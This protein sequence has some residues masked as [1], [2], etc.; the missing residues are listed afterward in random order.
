MV[1]IPDSLKPLIHSE[2]Y[3]IISV[4]SFRERCIKNSRESGFEG[5]LFEKRDFMIV[6]DH[7][8]L[9]K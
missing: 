1:K 9:L 3:Q 7:D 2:M 6:H 4:K 5:S 8:N